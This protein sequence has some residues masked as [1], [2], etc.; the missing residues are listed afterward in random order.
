MSNPR[1]HAAQTERTA[2]VD[3]EA[4]LDIELPESSDL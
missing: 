4:T 1:S 2:N 3:I